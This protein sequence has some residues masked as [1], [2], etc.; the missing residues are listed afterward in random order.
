M[1]QPT[2][3]SSSKV[4]ASA[5]QTS[6]DLDGEAIILNFDEGVYYALDHVGARTWEL[7]RQPRTVAEL[8][9]TL[10][11]EYQV[12]PER[13]EADLRSLLSE[14]S[15]AGLIEVVDESSG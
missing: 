7:L 12:A 6:T 1:E 14:L 13:C 5:R 10:V 3:S 2:I 4:V 8:R 11:A 9:D 15:G